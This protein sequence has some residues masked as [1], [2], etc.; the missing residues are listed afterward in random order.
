MLVDSHCHLNLLDYSNPKDNID[1]LDQVISNCIDNKLEHLLCVAIDLVGYHQILEIAE[2]YTNIPI[3][4]SAGVHPNE[5]NINIDTLK[6]ELL[7]QASNPKVIAIGETGLDY[8]RGEDEQQQAF[9][10]Q[11]LIT[12]IEV[13]KELQKPLIIHSRAAQKDTID[14]LAKYNANEC[15]GVMHCFTEDWGIAQ[16]ALDLGF[17]ISLSGIV[18]FKNATQVHEVAT[19]VPLDRLLIET[20][21]P[22]LAPIPNRGKPNFPHYVKHVAEKIAELRNIDFETVAKQTTEN[23]YQLFEV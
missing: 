14:I 3:S 10:Q 11:K 4:I 5:D 19:K 20:D 6:L 12:H 15:R 17:Y 21:C 7:N 16:Q 8:Y 9:Q 23:F 2:K 22:Y 13:A 1:N 18:S